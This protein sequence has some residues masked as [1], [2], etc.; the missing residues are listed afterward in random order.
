[1]ADPSVT[2]VETDAKPLFRGRLHQIGFFVVVPAG[3]LLIAGARSPV[4]RV[5]ATVYA[6]ALAGMYGTSALY[7]RLPWSP[8]GRRWM[9]RLDH[10]MIFV[11]IAGTYTPFSLLVLQPPWRWIVL[12]GVWGGAA[13]G[14]ALK[15][16]RIDGLRAV[17][18]ALYIVLG[19]LIVIASPELFGR[20]PWEASVLI[21]LGGL[22][23][24][25][26]AIV[27]AAHR[28]DPSPRVFGYHEV[29]H[30]MVLGGSVCHFAA[31]SLVVLAR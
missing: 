7:H 27:L 16:V 1:M 3:I 24:T 26:G 31:I 19:W 11:L 28:P 9:K 12:A 25:A 2:G 18:G 13:L 20:L 21:I 10:S 15:M 14:I 22:L 30:S 4:A 23:Y 5:A 29:W 6:I 17:G 8:N